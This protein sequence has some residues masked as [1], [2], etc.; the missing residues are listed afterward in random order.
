MDVLLSDYYKFWYHS[1]IDKDYSLGSYLDLSKDLKDCKI[2]TINELWQ[3][4]RKIDNG[5][6]KA[7]M[8]FLMRHE[9]MPIWEDKKNVN[10]GYWS[11]RI[12]KSEVNET[13]KKISAAFV[14]N[15]LMKNPENMSY[16]T[17]ISLSPKIGFCTVKIW[18]ND[19]SK[20]DRNL[21]GDFDFLDKNNMLYRT[22]KN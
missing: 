11:L 1:I 8:F 9:I 10:G 5:N 21:L 16:I 3:I 15:L 7:G 13:W 2:R 6:F 17:G 22:H 4:Y 20:T 19:S 12:N 14:G 18:N